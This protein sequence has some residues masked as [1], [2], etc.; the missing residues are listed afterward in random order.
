VPEITLP[1][2]G[3]K[4]YDVKLNAAIATINEAVDTTSAIVT[5]GRL[6]EA[7]LS[8]AIM[9]A[10]ADFAAV[11]PIEE[12]VQE[13]EQLVSDGSSPGDNSVIFQRAEDTFEAL[14]NV[15]KRPRQYAVPDGIYK[16]S[17]TAGTIGGSNPARCITKKS[18]AGIATS[19]Q[20]GVI[21]QAPADATPF[22]AAYAFGDIEDVYCDPHVVDCSAQTNSTY[23]TGLKGWFIQ[24]LKRAR[25]TNILVKNSWGTGFGC[26][27]LVDVVVT[28]EA[29]GCGRGIKVMGVDPLATSGG[30][31]FGIGT[32]RYEIENFYLDVTAKN[33]GFHGVFTETQP[34]PPFP[35]TRGSYIRAT[36]INNFVGFRDCGSDGLV[37]DITSIGN[38]YAGVLHDKTILAPSA[39]INGAVRLMSTSDNVGL[40][41]GDSH[42]GG[43]RFSGE[44][45]KAKTHGVLAPSSAFIGPRTAI[46]DIRVHDCAGSGLSISA[47]SQDLQLRRI[48]AW[49]NGQYDLA[50][51]GA[52][53]TATGLEVT[54]NDFRSGGY[55]IQQ[56][57]V[58][59][60]VDRNRGT[61]SAAPNAFPLIADLFEGPATSKMTDKVAQDGL[62][63]ATWAQNGLSMGRDG[64]GHLKA[65]S[66]AATV[67]ATLAARANGRL[68]T[69]LAALQMDGNRRANLLLRYLSS[70]NYWRITPRPTNGVSTWQLQKI[71]D[72]TAISVGAAGPLAA[73]TDAIEVILDGDSISWKVNGTTIATV[74]DSALSTAVG[75]GFSGQANLDPTTAW[76][77]IKF[78]QS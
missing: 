46:D 39:G 24:G 64:L 41:L 19:S 18:G 22:V 47:S 16:L 8:E 32:G 14:W 62:E 65:V 23:T 48:T 35:F 11:V 36:V 34:S 63:F 66:G 21:F 54:D 29:D 51:L 25:F 70:T 42:A 15:D 44:I 61:E 1:V 17:K 12:F 10:V 69:Q 6:S 75:I 49:A 53:K 3:E 5:E 71:I 50:I 28:G 40:M 72:G 43:Y 2:R 7:G 27:F 57:R 58:G 9:A 13:G 74:T 78:F 4:P 20:R 38:T 26:D 77:F 30:S 59:V 33:C 56:A 52:L 60:L 67:Y 76:D 45:L 31:G 68:T 37:A 73:A 55:V